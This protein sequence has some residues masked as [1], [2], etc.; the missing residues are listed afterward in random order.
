M[1]NSIILHSTPLKEF[2]DIIGS[3]VEE[4]LQQFKPEPPQ[5]N[6]TGEYLTRKEVCDLLRISLSTLHYYTKDGTLQGYR[7]GGR[8]LYKS[9]EVQNAVQEIQSTKYKHRGA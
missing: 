5:T 4:K 8:I 9:A 2:R 1:E 6:S 3:I 7:I